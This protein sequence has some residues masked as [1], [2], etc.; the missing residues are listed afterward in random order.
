MESEHGGFVA[1]FDFSGAFSQHAHKVPEAEGTFSD[2]RAVS[3]FTISTSVMS[4]EF[5]FCCLER[6]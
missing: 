4:A 6:G 2:S 1:V 5:P 3:D